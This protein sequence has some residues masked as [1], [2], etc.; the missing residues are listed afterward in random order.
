MLMIEERGA[1]GLERAH[2]P[3]TAALEAGRM[4]RC[5]LQAR[6]N[7]ARDA[8]PGGAGG[9]CDRQAVGMRNVLRTKFSR[10][11]NPVRR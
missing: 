8:G 2:V 1:A 10:R 11:E 4:E 3:C 6:D 7:I 9:L 5:E